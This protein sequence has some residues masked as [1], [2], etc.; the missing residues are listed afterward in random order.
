MEISGC[1]GEKVV[2]SSL[3]KGQN[4]GIFF[5]VCDVEFVAPLNYTSVDKL[6]MIS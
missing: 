1:D 4:S 3:N 5:E 2:R 6:L